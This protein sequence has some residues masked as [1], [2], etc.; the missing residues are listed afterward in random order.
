MALVAATTCRGDLRATHGDLLDEQNGRAGEVDGRDVAGHG[1]G[2]AEGAGGRHDRRANER[3]RCAARASKMVTVSAPGMGMF[4]SAAAEF[5]VNVNDAVPV[6]VRRA[7]LCARRSDGHRRERQRRCDG[8]D[9]G[10]EQSRGKRDPTGLLAN[11]QGV[12]SSKRCFRSRV[13]VP[14]TAAGPPP[15]AVPAFYVSFLVP[16]LDPAAPGAPCAPRA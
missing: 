14:G 2:C 7:A 3:D 10:R 11:V 8:C 5:S 12:R 16:G 6:E 9:E 15:V 1:R 13:L 4:G